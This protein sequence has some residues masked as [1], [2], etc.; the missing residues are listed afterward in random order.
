MGNRFIIIG[1]PR[2][3]STLLV[4]TLNSIDG[5]CCHGELLADKD[6]SIHIFDFPQSE[7]G[8]TSGG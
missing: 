1:A 5:I 3:G 4:R 2:T 7:N 8:N 6:Q